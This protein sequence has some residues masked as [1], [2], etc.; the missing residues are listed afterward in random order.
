[1]LK[2]AIYFNIKPPATGQ[3]PLYDTNCIFVV[4]FV[5]SSRQR[6]CCQRHSI[7]RPWVDRIWHCGA[8]DLDT[9]EDRG[10]YELNHHEVRQLSNILKQKR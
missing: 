3:A 1:M 5:T 4:F 9:S 2:L 10:I 6:Q 7:S 8:P